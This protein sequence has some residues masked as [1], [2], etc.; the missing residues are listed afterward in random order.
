MTRLTERC[1]VRDT[2]NKACKAL[3]RPGAGP[4]LSSVRSTRTSTLVFLGL[5]PAAFGFL[6]CTKNET[7]YQPTTSGT[8][9]KL[10]VSP[11]TLSIID[12]TPTAAAFLSTDAP[13]TLDWRVTGKPTWVRA[14]PESGKVSQGLLRV[15]LTAS[16]QGLPPGTHGGTIFFHSTGG[17]GRVVVRFAVAEHPIGEASIAAVHFAAG[18][19]QKT[20]TLTNRG[21]GIL[22]WSAASSAGWLS[23][24]P[25]GGTLTA[26]Q[27]RTLNATGTRSALPPG[28][29]STTLTISSNSEAGPIAIAATMD[30]PAAPILN[31]T[32]DTVRFDYFVNSATLKI[33][34]SGNAPLSWAAT[35]SLSSLQ[36][37]PASG[38]L[39]AGDTTAVILTAD[40][41]GLATGTY[42]GAITVTAPTLPNRT[43]GVSLKH[44]VETKWLLDDNIT[45]AEFD[46][47]HGRIVAVG[48]TSSQELLVLDPEARSTVSVALPL[49]ATCVSIRPDGL[50]AAAGHNGF[51]SYVNLSTSSVD[52]TYATTADAIDVVL[53]SNG[54]V[55]VFPRVDQWTTI[56]CINLATGAETQNT[57]FSLRAGSLAKLHPSGDYIY[58]ADNGLSPSDFEKY[59]IRPGT[60]AY[61]YDSPYHGDYAFSGNLWISDDGQRIFARS[62]NVF[63]SSPTQSQD[64]IY[65]GALPGASSV[66]WIDHSTAASRVFCLLTGASDVRVYSAGFLTLQGTRALPPFLVPNAT[67][68]GTLHGSSGRFVFA[69][70]IGTRV[71]L[72]VRAASGS[73]LLNDWA[74]A[75]FDLSALP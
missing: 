26:G 15:S 31:A 2:G 24:A 47:A 45:D 37:A 64:M 63:R 67:G 23:I 35:S 48:G 30:V 50:Y 22:S 40:R 12:T 56:R 27:S 58:V 16:P 14:D 28:T 6:G 36:L 57:G 55:Y 13:G 8:A 46:R 19:T 7:I 71:H 41:T 29:A 4:V 68:G 42:A 49:P 53:P 5:V 44:F 70:E 32:A 39:N 52:R 21:T 65:N 11:D 1:G 34:N 3:P 72:L 38:A 18:E 25:T 43:V 66:Q 51:V 75:S 59:D 61:M 17:E 10:V 9:P 69:N 54:W 74:V 33:W 20:F 73:G 62:G 60:A